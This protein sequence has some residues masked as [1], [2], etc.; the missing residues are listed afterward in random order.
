MNRKS[1]AG[2]GGVLAVII[3][4][5]LLIM[6]VMWTLSLFGHAVG[7]TPTYHDV[8]NRDKAW[9]HVHYP[10]VGWRY[11]LTALLL[12]AA[13]FG[14]E[15]TVRW[16]TRSPTD[17]TPPTARRIGASVAICFIALLGIRATI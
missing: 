16:L 5:G 7:L 15:R 13:A 8:M 12:L 4:I 3:V 1:S 17:R 9:L 10:N 14:V 6:A 2:W 11:T